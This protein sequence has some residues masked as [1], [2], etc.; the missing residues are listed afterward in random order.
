MKYAT[1]YT[2]ADGACPEIGQ[3]VAVMDP[4]KD[5]RPVLLARIIRFAPDGQVYAEITRVLDDRDLTAVRVGE[6]IRSSCHRLSVA[7]GRRIVD[8]AEPLMEDPA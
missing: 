7:A 3:L 1:A 8:Q 6:T 4:L 5:A 2:D